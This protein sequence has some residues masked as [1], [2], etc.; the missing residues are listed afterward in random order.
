[1][2]IEAGELIAGRYRK[3]GTIGVGGMARVVLAE[4]ERLRRRVAIKAL[5]A[6]SLDDSAQRFEREARIGAS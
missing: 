5:H 2:P 4:D 3:L 6:D 1:M